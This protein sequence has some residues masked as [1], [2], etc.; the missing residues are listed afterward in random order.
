MVGNCLLCGAPLA[1]T[2][3]SSFCSPEHKFLRSLRLLEAAATAHHGI[4]PVEIE[5]A[6][7]SEDMATQEAALQMKIAPH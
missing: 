1:P 4:N 5:Q 6:F 2:G 3:K 7:D